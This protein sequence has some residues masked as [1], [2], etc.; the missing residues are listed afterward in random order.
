M[1]AAYGFFA[2]YY[3]ALTKNVCYPERAEA[4]NRLIE[5]WMRP[6][7][8]EH[9][10]LDL[11]CGTGSLSEAFARR[12]WDVIGVD[13]SEEMLSEALDKKYDSGL[14]IQYLRQD[15]RRLDLYG[16]IAVTV[17]ALDS[18][19]HL[20]SSGDVRR[21]M[22]RVNLFSE[23]GALF[24]FDLNTEYKHRQLLADQCFVYELPDAV[25][26]W[27]NHLR[28]NEPEC[29]V[30]IR[31]DFFAHTEGRHY[32]RETEEFTERIWQPE[33]VRRLLAETGFTLL[34][35]LDGD[36]YDTPTNLTQRLLYIARAAG[37]QK[38]PATVLPD[39]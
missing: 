35:V 29:P 25:C 36:S 4:L 27:Q 14:P 10:L 26:V 1:T 15:M 20:Q 12:G 7:M 6:D 34:E 19:N 30:T 28:E 39:E 9:I 23:A 38:P 21:V 5:K 31:L 37:G 16:T 18:L 22:E 3:D 11:A 33:T 32:V 13:C 2:Q 17:C 8:P 24:L